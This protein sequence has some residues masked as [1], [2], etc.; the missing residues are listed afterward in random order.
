VTAYRLPAP[1]AGGEDGSA[2]TLIRAL[3]SAAATEVSLFCWEPAQAGAALPD[4]T[5]PAMA[6][7]AKTQ[8]LLTGYEFFRRVE[9]PSPLQGVSFRK[10]RREVTVFWSGSGGGSV[11]LRL[12]DAGGQVLDVQGKGI[13]TLPAGDSSVSLTESPVFVVG[14]VRVTG[15]KA[16]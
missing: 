7:W 4:M 6:A 15:S 14:T 12:K 16:G 2:A 8:A 3:A 9:L 13:K 1:G 5:S 10:G 11:D